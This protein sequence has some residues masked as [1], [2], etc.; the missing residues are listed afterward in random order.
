MTATNALGW[1]S[2]RS[3]TLPVAYSPDW[4]PFGV[5]NAMMGS[6]SITQGELSDS[7]EIPPNPGW[8]MLRLGDSPWNGMNFDLDFVFADSP[9]ENE[10]RASIRRA[11]GIV[12]IVQ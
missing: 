9:F 10:W 2:F 3:E 12:I 7:A 1:R 5:T 6:F 11:G 8:R 4:V